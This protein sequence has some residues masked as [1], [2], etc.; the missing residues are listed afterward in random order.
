MKVIDE[1]LQNYMEDKDKH[2]LSGP[3][4][5]R[6]LAIEKELQ[7]TPDCFRLIKILYDET[8]NFV[9]YPTLLGVKVVNLKTNKVVRLIGKDFLLL[10]IYLF[11]HFLC[12]ISLI[13]F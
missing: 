11:L 7:T 9:L 6:R 13:F 3:E 4:F 12:F 8:S 1:G 10:I 5:N 2:G